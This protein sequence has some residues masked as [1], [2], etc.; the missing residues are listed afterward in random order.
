MY[1]PLKNIKYVKL[2]IV[3]PAYEILINLA[4]IIL[5]F[6]IS[7][8]IQSQGIQMTNYQLTELISETF[9]EVTFRSIK[10]KS[11][12]YSYVDFLVDKLYEYDPV[13]KENSIPYYIPYGSIRLKKFSN[14]GCAEKYKELKKSGKICTTD[15]CTLE[16]LTDFYKTENC[17]SAF[18]NSVGD[19]SNSTHLNLA[20][21]FEG[22]YSSYNLVKEGTNLDFT[23]DEY[24]DNSKNNSTQQY[25]TSFI[26][27]DDDIKFIAL[28][29][30]VYFPYDDSH[31]IIIA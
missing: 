4:I 29:F 5:F 13:N 12:F 11:D 9:D 17:G 28:L 25:I 21:R 22:K 15:K 7:F 27:N 24:Y 10:K 1:I 30:N 31:A 3:S 20:R 18:S 2:C 8:L 23:I 14:S 6:I 26:G 16:L 19:V